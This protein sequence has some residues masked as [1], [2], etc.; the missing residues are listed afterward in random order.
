MGHCTFH[1]KITFS[2]TTNVLSVSFVQLFPLYIMLKLR[3]TILSNL[4]PCP[5]SLGSTD[6]D[7]ENVRPSKILPLPCGN[8]PA[9]ADP[10]A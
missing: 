1:G 5:I 10:K 4:L 6:S 7:V 9:S 2:D 3:L 8:T